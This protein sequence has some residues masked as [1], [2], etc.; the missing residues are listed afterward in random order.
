MS[1]MT[2]WT[3]ETDN[4]D[5]GRDYGG[6]IALLRQL[7]GA[8]L[9]WCYKSWRQLHVAS[10]AAYCYAADYS[11]QLQQHL[12]LHRVLTV[13]RYVDC[14]AA[15]ISDDQEVNQMVFHDTTTQQLHPADPCDWQRWAGDRSWR[16]LG[17]VTW[18]VVS[19]LHVLGHLLPWF[20][21]IVSVIAQL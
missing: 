21:L 18:R 9:T 15:S 4:G 10:C 2:G 19:K 11:N 1:K 6:G 3:D 7:L 8:A 20:S 17:A 12:G 16:L 14:S 13:L 5:W